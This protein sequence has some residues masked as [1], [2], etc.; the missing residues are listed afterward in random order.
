MTN[1]NWRSK[2]KVTID[3][4]NVDLSATGL[5]DLTAITLQSVQSYNPQVTTN[6]DVNDSITNERIGYLIRPGRI[7]IALT[8]LAAKS[9][10]LT[11]NGGLSDSEVLQI[12][13]FIRAE[14][15]M[16]IEHDTGPDDF[17]ESW[18]WEN[19][20]ILDSNPSQLTLDTRPNAIF[21][22]AALGVTQANLDEGGY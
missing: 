7:T 5:K 11:I 6:A 9:L 8:V 15:D 10:D 1:I 19:C 3:N 2:I 20:L 14:F 16:I 12:L 21:N 17:G 22:M 18:T 4:I 13:Q